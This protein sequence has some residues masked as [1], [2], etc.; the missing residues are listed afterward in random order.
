MVV[1]HLQ[2]QGGSGGGG[3]RGDERNRGFLIDF[4]PAILDSG[5]GD[6]VVIKM[7]STAPPTCKNNNVFIVGAMAETVAAVNLLTPGRSSVSCKDN[8]LGGKGS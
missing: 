6:N 8:A 1:H 2:H 5:E 4:D 3:G 7:T